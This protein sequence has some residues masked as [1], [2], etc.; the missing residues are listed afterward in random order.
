MAAL[1]C[2]QVDTTLSWASGFLLVIAAIIMRPQQTPVQQHQAISAPDCAKAPL[3]LLNAPR[4][5]FKLQSDCGQ[6]GCQASCSALCITDHPRAS[7]ELS[8]LLMRPACHCMPTS[9]LT[10]QMRID[11]RCLIEVQAQPF[12][13][14][15]WGID[16]N[17]TTSC[18]VHAVPG[19]LVHKSGRWC[20]QL[21][22]GP[23]LLLC[24]GI[25]A[26]CSVPAFR[27]WPGQMHKRGL[28]C[29]QPAPQPYLLHCCA[30]KLTAPSLLS[31][32]RPLL[33]NHA[34]IMPGSSHCQA[35]CTSHPSQ[36][37][38]SRANPAEPC[39]PRLCLAQ[40]CCLQAHWP[41]QWMQGRTAPFLVTDLP[42]HKGISRRLLAE[43]PPA[44]VCQSTTDF[45]KVSRLAGAARDV[46]T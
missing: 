40:A 12:S 24:K 13:N 28:W 6:L 34:S 5:S 45:V 14:Y 23:Y 8:L 22:A 11:S 41:E 38:P 25:K 46:T 15:A 32:Q 39:L 21:H 10:Q 33:P 29:C 17:R 3:K 27:L 43:F 36:V 19:S 20:A 18:M 26:H 16:T 2:L 30:S 37:A 35:A 44:H 42:R 1:C 4:L 7:V 31:F 9:C